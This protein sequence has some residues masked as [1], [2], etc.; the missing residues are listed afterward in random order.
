MTAFRPFFFVATLA[1]YRLQSQETSMK[2][3]LLAIALMIAVP[4]F[5]QEQPASEASIRDRL[6]ASAPCLA[7]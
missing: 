3:L 1:N 2:K 6:L 4:S 5:A 7:S